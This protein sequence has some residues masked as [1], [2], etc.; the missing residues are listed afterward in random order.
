MPPRAGGAKA[1]DAGGDITCATDADG[2][3]VYE[4]RVTF[5]TG[6]EFLHGLAWHDG[7]LWYTTSGSIRKARDT[8]SDGVADDNVVVIGEDR[9]PSGGAH[10]W[11]SIAIAHGRIYTSIGD[12]GNITDEIATDRQKIWSYALDGSDRK[13]FAS[14]IRNTEK[15]RVR[16]GTT[17]LWGLDHGSDWFGKIYAEDPANPA[18]GMP[19]TDDNPGEEINKY[20]EGGFYGHPFIV[21]GGI[22]RPEF[23]SRSDIVELGQRAV[24]PELLMPAHWAGNGFCFVTLPTPERG[25]E[26]AESLPRDHAGDMIACYHG[27]WN[28]SEPGGY[29]VVRVMFDA[30]ENRPIGYVKLVD[31]LDKATKGAILRPVDAIQRPDGSVL[32][33]CDLSGRVYRLCASEK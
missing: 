31:G 29:C 21:G 15:L 3:G 10:W 23:A 5:L 1:N 22:P 30:N 13:I 2:D 6:P 7:W 28:R 20:V 17:E 12:S 18:K 19:F 16:P 14:G 24:A 27:S 9:L 11:R 25:A 4:S 8:S 33:S 32:F 26:R